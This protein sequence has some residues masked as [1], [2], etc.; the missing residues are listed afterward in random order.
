MN[1]SARSAQRTRDALCCTPYSITSFQIV[2]SREKQ[3]KEQLPVVPRI[4]GGEQ[5]I[6]QSFLPLAGNEIANTAPAPRLLILAHQS[7][8]SEFRDRGV[9]LPETDR[10]EIRRPLLVSLLDLVTGHGPELQHPQHGEWN[11]WP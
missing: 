2:R 9:N 11:R 1:A 10:H 7:F 4:A 8:F 5:P 6:P 3:P